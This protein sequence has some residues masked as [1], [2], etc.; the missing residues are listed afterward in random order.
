MLTVRG[1][2][3]ISGDAHTKAAPEAAVSGDNPSG[4]PRT[5]SRLRHVTM[6]ITPRHDHRA[7]TTDEV[8]LGSGRD[9]LA[10]VKVVAAAKTTSELRSCVK[11]EVVFLGSRP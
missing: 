6:S 7:V 2:R 1:G 5:V 9:V 11:V 10:T 3:F 8:E 4:F